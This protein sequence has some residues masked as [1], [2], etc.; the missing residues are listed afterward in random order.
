MSALE[1]VLEKQ[2]L[3]RFSSLS[4][5][6]NSKSND[7]TGG[8]CEGQAPPAVTLVLDDSLRHVDDEVGVNVC[9]MIV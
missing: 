6:K 3:L 7:R 8:A 1:A 9:L 2:E 4:Q 5:L